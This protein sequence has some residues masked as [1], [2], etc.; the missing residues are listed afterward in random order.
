MDGSSCHTKVPTKATWRVHRRPPSASQALMSCKSQ[1]D[2]CS[3]GVR[4][5]LPPLLVS[6]AEAHSG[7][8]SAVRLRGACLVET[9]IPGTTGVLRAGPR[10]T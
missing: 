6:A 10:L 9:T 7:E 8:G 1:W 3:A 5:V 4:S 2:A